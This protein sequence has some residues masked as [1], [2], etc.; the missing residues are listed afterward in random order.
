[1]PQAPTPERDEPTQAEPAASIAEGI[2][3][4]REAAPPSRPT[5]SAPTLVPV[6]VEP[7]AA[8]PEPSAAPAS[9]EDDPL[10]ARWA[11]VAVAALVALSAGAAWTLGVWSRD[12][13]SAGR[14]VGSSLPTAAREAAGPGSLTTRI[15]VLPDGRLRV[16]QS[17]RTPEPMTSIVVAAPV[18]PY[19]ALGTVTASELHVTAG[20]ERAHGAERVTL[21]SASFAFDE[22]TSVRLSYVLSGALQRADGSARALARVT[23]LD[24]F[25]GRDL[26]QATYVVSGAHVLNLACSE[27]GSDAPPQPCGERH[28]E[29][30]VVR[31]SQSGS[32]LSRVMAQLDLV[33]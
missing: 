15:R 1:V 16:H 31:I 10:R 6:P 29:E 8:P 7:S 13:P 9:E 32:E 30:W 28:G 11:I 24:L 23:S 33:S 14:S 3:R 22:T 5:R 21:A 27:A 4:A 25:T 19:L 20:G 18:D 26:R 2:P 12:H 17:I